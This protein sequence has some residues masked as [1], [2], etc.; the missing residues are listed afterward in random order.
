M[1]LNCQEIF[2]GWC[3]HL[4]ASFAYGYHVLDPYSPLAGKIHTRLNRDHHAG[5]QNILLAG[6][7]SGHFVDFKSHPM[8]GR[9]SK[10]LCQPRFAQYLA[11]RLVYFRYAYPR[12]NRRNGGQLCFFHR[13]VSKAR[14]FRSAAH[15][16]GA[17]LV[18]TI[19]SEYNTEITHYESAGG[20]QFSR[21]SAVRQ[22]RSTSRSDDGGK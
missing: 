8:P 20:D 14:L 17:R 11:S 4:A 15:P 2:A 16:N 13:F 19:T 5:P 1:T 9:V 3:Q 10:I 18:R 21:S 7:Y 6:C 12:P 22:R